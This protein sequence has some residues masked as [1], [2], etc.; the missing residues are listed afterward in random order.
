MCGTLKILDN[1]PILDKWYIHNNQRINLGTI[2]LRRTK[3]ESPVGKIHFLVQVRLYTCTIIYCTC[4]VSNGTQTQVLWNTLHITLYAIYGKNEFYPFIQKLRQLPKLC[5]HLANQ[6]FKSHL[7][8]I[9]SESES[10]AIIGK[11]KLSENM[12]CR[13]YRNCQN[14]QN[15]G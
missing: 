12:I 14:F 13:S 11:S 10:A 5:P 1:P 7:L 3:T 8:M 9:D 6:W 2:T 4:K 15:S